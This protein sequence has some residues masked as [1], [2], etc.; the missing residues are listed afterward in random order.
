MRLYL[1]RHAQP[2]TL[3]ENSLLSSIG[4]DQVNQV[5]VLLSQLCLDL[6]QVTVLTTKSPRAQQTGEIISHGLAISSDHVTQIPNVIGSGDAFHL[7][8]LLYHIRKQTEKGRDEVIFVG[9]A[10]YFPLLI[11]HF[12]G[13]FQIDL[14]PSHCSLI[15]LEGASESKGDWQRHWWLAPMPTTMEPAELLP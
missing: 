1:M 5:V 4:E 3:N 10:P 2:L 14:S 9:H 11:K 6:E 15:S 7:A 13:A 8:Y 12:T